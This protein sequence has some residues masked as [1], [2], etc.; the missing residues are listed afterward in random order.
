[1]K[2]TLIILLLFTLIGCERAYIK[3]FKIEGIGIGDSL[4]DYFTEKQIAEGMLEMEE[5]NL[6][7]DGNFKEF[8]AAEFRFENFENYDALQIYFKP[9]DERYEIYGINGIIDYQDINNCYLKQNEIVEEFSVT[10]K[11]SEKYELSFPNP[12]DET[13]NSMIKRT[14]FLLKS[15]SSAMVS[16]YDWSDDFIKKGL[17]DKIKWIKHLRISINEKERSEYLLVS[18]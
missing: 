10:F 1:M 17:A 13:D 8:I 7:K 12:I 4:L 14:S 2:K 3:D 15:G 9:N 5:Y 16:C 18:F 11:N 6:T